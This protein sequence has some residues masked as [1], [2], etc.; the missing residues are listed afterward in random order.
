MKTKDK[1]NTKK[2][3]LEVLE[4]IPFRDEEHKKQIVCS[5]IGCSTI[6]TTCFGYRYCARCGRQL[7]DSLGSIDS[8]IKEAVIVEHNCP[9]CVANY[10][11][12]NWKDKFLSPSKKE[13]FKKQ[14]IVI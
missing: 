7:G 9:E 2:Q 14:E 5:L 6:S 11:K 8:G 12:C 4:K 13:I 3:L 1:I 10:K